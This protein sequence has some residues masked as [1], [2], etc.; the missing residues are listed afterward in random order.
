MSLLKKIQTFFS[1]KKTPKSKTLDQGFYVTK[2]RNQHGV[3]LVR[4]HKSWIRE[5]GIKLGSEVVVEK[6]GS[7]PF[8][9]ELVIKPKH[10]KV[11][12]RKEGE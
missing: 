9:W 3:A 1:R 10:Q 12:E 5:L 8:Q 6:R 11:M 4:I 7:N 2:V